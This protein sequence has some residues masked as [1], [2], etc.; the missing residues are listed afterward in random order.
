[1]RKSPVD[2]P[3]LK[4][5]RALAYLFQHKFHL[6]KKRIFLPNYGTQK[7]KLKTCFS[8]ISKGKTC[9]SQNELSQAKI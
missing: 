2:F 6:N 9:F 3:N 1:M 4:M 7:I 5:F 8:Q